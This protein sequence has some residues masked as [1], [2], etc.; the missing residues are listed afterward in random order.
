MEISEGVYKCTVCNF[1]NIFYEGGDVEPWISCRCLGRA[2]LSCLREIKFTSCCKCN[3][4]TIKSQF[5]KV[6]DLYCISEY[7]KYS[8]CPL[9]K[10][11][12]PKIIPDVLQFN[13]TDIK[14]LC[15]ELGFS[16]EIFFQEKIDGSKFLCLTLSD[17]KKLGFKCGPSAKIHHHIQ[18]LRWKALNS[19]MH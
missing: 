8:N 4:V 6:K 18:I 5:D 19:N 2:H 10:I 12:H 15:D 17:L 3:P 13:S 14:E 7:K 16:G 11:K 9:E 1:G